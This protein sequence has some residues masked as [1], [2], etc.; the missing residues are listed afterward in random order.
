VT[1]LARCV[2]DVERFLG[3]HWGRAPLH[4]SGIDAGGFGDLLSLADVDHLVSSTFLRL[5]AL[6]LVRD[7]TP[8][9]PATYTRSARLGGRQ[10]ADA[11]DP[12]RVYE[13]FRA[14]ATIVLQGLHRS[15][16]PLTRF[17]RQLELEI[18][19]P[20]QVNAYVTPPSARGLAVHYDTH[21]VFVLQFGGSKRWSV[22]EP[23]LEDPLPSQPWSSGRGR[24]GEPILTARLDAGDVLYVPRGFLHSAQAQE[25]VSAH[26]TVGIVA[27][28]WADVV[29]TATKGIEDEVDFRRALPVG[30]AHDPESLAPAV[31]AHLERLRAWLEKVDVEAVAERTARRF[32]SGRPPL[33]AGQLRQLSLLEHVDDRS[34]VRRREGAVCRIEVDGARLQLLLGD[35]ELHMPAGLEPAVARITATSEMRVG[36][37]AEHLDQASRLV[38]VRRLVREGLLEVV[39]VG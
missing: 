27:S 7:G 9:D 6:R 38:L 26:L 15:W 2:G 33:L 18:T 13:Q 36:D 8:L 35:R 16:P 11:A 29:R 34:R 31:A 39:D 12:G 1:S 25:G 28:T 3:D 22:Y 17:C 19:H 23:V 21:D 20:V 4:L 37:L 24:P 30:F 5:P 10:L 14:G 32:W